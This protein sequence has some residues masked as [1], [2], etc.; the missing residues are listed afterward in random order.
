MKNIVVVCESEQ[1]NNKLLAEQFESKAG[2]LAKGLE[3]FN[4]IG[5]RAIVWF[6]GREVGEAL[7]TIVAV[8][9]EDAEFKHLLEQAL[10]SYN[11]LPW[12]AH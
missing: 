4:E 2:Y 5:I 12:A 11:H 9:C 8:E 1:I 10:E 6:K 7:F 3:R